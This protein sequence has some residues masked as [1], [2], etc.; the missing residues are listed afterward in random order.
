MAVSGVTIDGIDRLNARFKKI[1]ELNAVKKDLAE[2]VQNTARGSAIKVP[3]RTGRLAHSQTSSSVGLQGEVAYT[4]PY[5]YFV[6]EGT[7]YMAG[8][9]YLFPVFY[10]ERAKLLIN[11]RKDI[12]A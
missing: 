11:I 12:L 6:E 7:R 1:Q 10:V 8:R 3:Y 5:A 4:A 2:A 9:H